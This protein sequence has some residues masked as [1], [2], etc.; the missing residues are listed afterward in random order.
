M[1]ELLEQAAAY[2]G[3][4]YTV[5]QA[6][7]HRPEA[8]SFVVALTAAHPGAGTSHLTEVLA[9]ALRQDASGRAL[10]L[11]GRHLAEMSGA[12]ESLMSDAVSPRGGGGEL[13]PCPAEFKGSWRGSR[14]YR[15]AYLARLRQQ[16]RY[17]LID[18]PSF[19][20]SQDILGLAS[21]VDGIMIVVEAN[22]TTTNQV[23]YLERTLEGAGGKILGHLLNKRTYPIPEWFH[24][25]ME[26]LGI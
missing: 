7:L 11:D 13:L 21:L 9:E 5:F 17:V 16:F 2:Q 3:V 14:E 20:E 4:I 18:C 25:R 12:P 8:D 1:T 15:A 24:T 22:R 10:T 19:K 26:K 6:P 23:S